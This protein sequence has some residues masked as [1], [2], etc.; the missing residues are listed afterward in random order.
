[1]FKQSFSNWTQEKK[2]M[3]NN[4]PMSQ[5]VEP[6][7]KDEKT[8][9]VSAHETLSDKGKDILSPG[10][11][12]D[13][14]TVALLEYD[15]SSPTEPETKEDNSSVFKLN[16]WQQWLQ[17]VST[18]LVSQYRSASDDM[19][20]HDARVH[21][22]CR[23]APRWSRP[24]NSARN[25]GALITAWT[26]SVNAELQRDK[27]IEAMEQ[28]IKQRPD[29]VLQH[30]PTNFPVELGR[31]VLEYERIDGIS[32]DKLKAE[33]KSEEKENL[34]GLADLYAGMEVAT[35]V[36][37]VPCCCYDWWYT[38]FCCAPFCQCFCTPKVRGL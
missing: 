20:R 26:K 18:S 4:T 27:I 12:E 11:E 38:I 8:L 10:L 6:E 14:E 31:L 19:I 22:L 16:A 13:K 7:T 29:T 23:L 17:S 35:A 28:N 32:L 24:E 2:N 25:I 1:M 30:L 36:G 33:L 34:Q 21:R 37:P 5:T 3:D 15:A 9:D